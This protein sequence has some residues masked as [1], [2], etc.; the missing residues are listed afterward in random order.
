[1]VE[2]FVVTLITMIGSMI[3][4]FGGWIIS[5]DNCSFSVF[6]KKNFLMYIFIN[7]VMLF[8]YYLLISK[9]DYALLMVNQT[10][11]K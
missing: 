3:G 1:M 5:N 10:L 8:V 6:I 7:I 11:S 4:F 2:F 9:I